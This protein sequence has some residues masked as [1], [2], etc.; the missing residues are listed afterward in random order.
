MRTNLTTEQIIAIATQAA[1]EAVLALIE[2]DAPAKVTRPASKAPKTAK[3]QVKRVTREVRTASHAFQGERVGTGTRKLTKANR[4][5]FIAAHAWAKSG[6]ST[7]A[8][9]S[10]VAMGAKVNKGW[11]VAI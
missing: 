10:E 4:A 9:R 8:L 5:A 6:F 2:P 7:A 1:T 3:P 11:N